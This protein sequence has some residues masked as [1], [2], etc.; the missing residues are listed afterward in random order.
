MNSVI[1]VEDDAASALDT[2]IVSVITVKEAGCLDKDGQSLQ[3]ADQDGEEA[4]PDIPA[5]KVEDENLTLSMNQFELLLSDL[6]TKHLAEK[7]MLQCDLSLC[8]KV[9][10]LMASCMKA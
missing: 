4:G 1:R 8:K 3:A 2:S 10:K 5:G 6:K 7:R 9:I